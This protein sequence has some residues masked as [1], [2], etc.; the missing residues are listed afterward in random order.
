VHGLRILS[1]T[2]LGLAMGLGATDSCAEDSS[3]TPGLYQVEVRLS[4]PNVDNAAVLNT[5]TRCV[6]PADLQSGRAFFVLSDNP[7]KQ[8]ELLDYHLATQTALYRIACPGPN[9]GSAVAV[10]ETTQIS[11]RGTIKMNMGGKNMTM[12]EVQVGK[13]IAECP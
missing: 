5:V 11:Y 10:F 6:T 12:S 3:L 4:L 8:C 13:R 1:G 7:L 2:I 9:R